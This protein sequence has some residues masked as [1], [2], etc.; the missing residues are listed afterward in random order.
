M[1]MLDAL[2]VVKLEKRVAN[3]DMGQESPDLA[4]AYSLNSK[5]DLNF[6]GTK[7]SPNNAKFM[8]FMNQNPTTELI[9]F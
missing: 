4:K 1:M 7:V 5:S 8:Q 6:E 3:E 2:N 9:T